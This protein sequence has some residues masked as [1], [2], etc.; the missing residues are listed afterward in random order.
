M[1]RA[2]TAAAAPA[3]ALRMSREA[4]GATARTLRADL[5]CTLMPVETLAERAFIKEREGTKGDV[6]SSVLA[7][8][9]F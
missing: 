7:R 6:V 5:A 1:L 4:T 2:R 3:A 8:S 9:K